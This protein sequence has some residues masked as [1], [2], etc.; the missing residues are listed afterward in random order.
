VPYRRRPIQATYFHGGSN[1]LIWQVEDQR[2]VDDRPEVLGW[3]SEIVSFA[4][5]L[6]A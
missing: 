5:A 6:Q 3:E 4:F 2:F 1:W